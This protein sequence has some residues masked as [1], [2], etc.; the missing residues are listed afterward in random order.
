MKA[1]AGDGPKRRLA[2]GLAVSAPTLQP[3]CGKQGRR[4]SQW[5][6]WGCLAGANSFVMARGLPLPPKGMHLHDG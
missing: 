5:G 2:L 6:L 4:Y 1:R 3:R